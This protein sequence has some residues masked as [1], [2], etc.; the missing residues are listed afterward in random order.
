MNYTEEALVFECANDRLVGILNKPDSP[1]NTGVIVIVGGPQYRAGSHRQF[2]L[3]ARHLSANG[4]ATL[5]FDYRGMGDSSG[6]PV[7]FENAHEDVRAA[8]WAYDAIVFV[9]KGKPAQ[10]LR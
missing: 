1:G 9:P 5:R 8:I 2:V 3:L 10:A 6:D 4:I 7:G